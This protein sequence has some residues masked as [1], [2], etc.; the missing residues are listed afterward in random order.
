MQLKPS[1][2]AEAGLTQDTGEAGLTQDAGEAGLTQDAAE[3]GA[4]TFDA[5][6]AGV[7]LGEA[8]ALHQVVEALL[9]HHGPHVWGQLF[10]QLPAMFSPDLITH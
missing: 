4:A 1:D 8:G 6:I 5:P 9:P 10:P 7:V 3:V 2:T